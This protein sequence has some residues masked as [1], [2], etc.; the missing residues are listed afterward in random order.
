MKFF[1][2]FI[3]CL[4][5]CAL[6]VSP[7]VAQE[8]TSSRILKNMGVSTAPADLVAF[9]E[10]GPSRPLDPQKLAENAIPFTQ[11]LIM[12]MQE[13]A[14]IQ[15]APAVPVLIRTASGDFPRGQT[16]FIDY[17]CRDLPPS[18][19]EGK[20]KTYQQFLIFN[21]INALGLIGDPSALPTLKEVFDSSSAEYMKIN[22]ALAMASLDYGG[23]VSYIVKKTREKNRALAAES[24]RALSAITGLELD[25][26]PYTPV[27]R[28]ERTIARVNKWWE[29]NKNTFRPNGEE[30]RKRRLSKVTPIPPRLSSM[31][32]LVM[33][34]ANYDDVDNKL[35]SLD[36]REK[37]ASM[38]VTIL[39]HLLPFCTDPEE[40]LNI[41]MEALRHYVQLG[42][43]EE[44]NAVLKKA[45]KD[46][47]PEIKELV[48]TLYDQWKRK[49]K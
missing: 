46:K 9:I 21:A 45:K 25:Y 2:V 28:R 24:C 4:L 32:E 31:R 48:R 37:L 3:I 44:V 41:R 43:A 11:L 1:K 26:A 23:G 19:Q 20:K 39:P 7:A 42:N 22:A 6:C 38:G 27:V 18:S 49:Q 34:A 14:E 30:I 16:A 8:K 13:L 40:N 10:N 29:Q 47:N 36:A 33:A 17:D 15:Y 12:A 5:L 35:M